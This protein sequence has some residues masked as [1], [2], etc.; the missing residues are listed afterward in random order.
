MSSTSP[1]T[2]RGGDFTPEAQALRVRITFRHRDQNTSDAA[3]RAARPAHT[4]ELMPPESPSTSPR[5]RSSEPSCDRSFSTMRPVSASGSISS[6]FAEKD[7]V[8]KEF[9]L[10][11]FTLQGFA[12]ETPANFSSIGFGEVCTESTVWGRRNPP[13][14]GHSAG[15]PHAQSAWVAC[16]HHGYDG[17]PEDSVGNARDDSFGN[18]RVRVENGLD[19]LRRNL[20][21]AGLDDVVL[22]A[23][24]VEKAFVVNLEGSPV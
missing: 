3:A 16:D 11:C 10:S 13:D 22:A 2:E 5:L 6:V 7:L 23:D 24:E 15:S 8:L 4:L 20:L 14:V 1:V 19:F 17:L 18:L 12:R 21:A 9:L